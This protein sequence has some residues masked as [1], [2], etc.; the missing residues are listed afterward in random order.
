MPFAVN[1]KKHRIKKGY[2]L[3]KLANEV[4][5]SKAH[6]WDL[7]TGRATNPSLDVLKKLS[8]KLDAPIASLVGEN[9]DSEDQIAESVVLYRDLQ[10]LRAEDR[11]TIKL[12]MERLK[13]RPTPSKG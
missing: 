13:I 4:G 1:L 5:V 3:Q 8:F 6:I 11:E 7:E 2:S 10:K 12:M 9:P